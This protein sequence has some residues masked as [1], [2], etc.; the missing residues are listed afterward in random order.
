MLTSTASAIRSS[1]QAGPPGAASALS[2]MRAWASFWAA[3]LPAAIRSRQVLAFV[4]GQR[5]LVL[6]H[7][8][9][10]DGVCPSGVPIRHRVRKLTVA[11]DH[12]QVE[13]RPAS[14]DGHRLAE[15]GRIEEFADARQDGAGWTDM[16][17]LWCAAG[18]AGLARHHPSG[19]GVGSGRWLPG[20]LRFLTGYSTYREPCSSVAGWGFSDSQAVFAS[21]GEGGVVG[22]VWL[23]LNG[24]SG[25]RVGLWCRL[26]PVQCLRRRIG[27][28]GLELQSGVSLADEPAVGGYLRGEPDAEPTRCT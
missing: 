25:E 13:V 17:M 7:G 14:A 19:V 22:P 28:C 8:L 11:V 12:C 21:V 24:V 27:C 3:A 6:L 26:L 15:M 4:G 16:Y 23:S 2:R 20:S 18:A 9:P 10:P 1:V 5:D